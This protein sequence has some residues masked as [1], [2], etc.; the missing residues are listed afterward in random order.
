MDAI[1]T[2]RILATLPQRLSAIPRRWAERAPQAWALHDGARPWTYAELTAAIDATVAQLRALQIRPGDRL[3]VVG[4]NC[5]AQVAL[6]FAA[7]ELDA[8]IVNVNGRLSAREVDQI[9]DH[10]GARRVIYTSAPGDAS[11]P[12]TAHASVPSSPE[13]A[14]HGLRHGASAAPSPFGQWMV[15][16]LNT[17]CAPE[18][19]H[20]ASSQQVAA[21]IYTTGT[22]GQPK[23]VM[24]THRNLLFIAAVSSTLRGLTTSDRAYGVLPITHVYGLASVMLGTLYAGACLY[25]CPRFAPDAVLK[26][27][28]DDGLT[29]LQ[30]VPAMYARLLETLGDTNQSLASRLRFIYAGGSPLAPSLK[31]RVEQLFGLTLHNGYGMTE[32]SPT[33]S[34]TRLDQPRGDDSVGQ[35]IPGV[36]VRLVDAGGADVVDDAAGE[37]WVRGPNIMAGYYREPELTAAAMRDGGWL[38]T[39]DVARRDTDGAL[40]I[41]G[42]TKELIIRSGFNVY[43]LEVETVLNAHPAVTQSAVVGRVAGDGNEEV[44]AFVEIDPRRQVTTEELQ[45]YLAGLLSPY[46]CPSEI[47]AMQALP[48][49]ATGKILKGQLRQMAQR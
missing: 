19:V 42:R 30:G 47:I 37:L 1:D 31:A 16:A 5:A 34:Q 2:A 15:G 43:P 36:E 45:Q 40:F 12:A 10:S 48:A 11:A 6:I 23:G 38:N 21:L 20:T 18:P 49:A 17:D 9:R 27:I 26:A 28:R 33:I 14:A 39:G 46:K 29:I 25:L 41:V 13:T 7:A 4:E 24:L 8:W 35:A 22:T 32:T 44:V 3:M